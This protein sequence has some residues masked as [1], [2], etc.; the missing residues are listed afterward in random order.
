[1][2]NTDIKKG[3]PVNWNNKIR[4]SYWAICIIVALIGVAGWP[5]I[6]FDDQ[7][8]LEDHIR[9]V[10]ILQNSILLGI[11]I[12]AEFIF[13]IKSR[14][15]DY[16]IIV[17]GV[18][19]ASTIFSLTAVNV[20][21]NQVIMLVPIVISILF[22][23]YRKV[24]FAGLLMISTY[25][26]LLMILPSYQ[27][28]IPLQQ[29]TL[30]IGSIMCCSF[31]ALGIVKRGLNIMKEEEK[32]ILEEDRLIR[33]K[34]SMGQ[35]VRMDALTGLNNHRT[36]QEQLQLTMKQRCSQELPIHLAIMDIDNFKHVNDSYGHWAGDIVLRRMGILID[37]H[38]NEDVFAARYG[39][40]EFAILFTSVASS[41]VAEWLSALYEGLARM[42]LPE[43]GDLKITISVGCHIVGA[44]EDKET[45]FQRADQALYVAKSRG[46]NQ[47][48]WSECIP[49]ILSSEDSI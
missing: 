41:E 18:C 30:V 38:T 32:V 3:K 1:M 19:I 17:I 36:F 7:T 45:I 39:G 47:V 29:V 5:N 26:T 22:F 48:V 6:P 43:T 31:L 14:F 13:R 24:I 15:Q 12:L 4:K 28:G 33:Q 40:E 2:D 34:L 49:R 11:M 44:R 25:L 42:Q 23:N 10:L 20:Y 16:L 21:G 35:L 27:G 37:E 46:K 9:I 8:T